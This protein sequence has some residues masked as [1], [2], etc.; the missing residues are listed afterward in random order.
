MPEEEAMNA[1]EEEVR[2]LLFQETVI[3]MIGEDLYKEA[4]ILY[5]ES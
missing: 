2:C 3:E 4:L 1:Y 5:G